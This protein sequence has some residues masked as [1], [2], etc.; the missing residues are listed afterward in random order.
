MGAKTL[1]QE[2]ILG[3]TTLIWSPDSRYLL[4]KKFNLGCG[5]SGLGGVGTLEVVDVGT[6]KRTEVESS[7]CAVDRNTIGWVSSDIRP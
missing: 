3:S 5:L 7:S 6:G 1:S 4:N 2:R